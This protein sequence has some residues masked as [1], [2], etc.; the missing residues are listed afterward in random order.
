VNE[1]TRPGV[2]KYLNQGA[3]AAVQARRDDAYRQMYDSCWGFY[4]IVAEGPRSEGGTA[5]AIGGTVFFDD[6][7]YWYIH[8]KC[9]P[10]PPGYDSRSGDGVGAGEREPWRR[11]SQWGPGP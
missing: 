8:F 3:D 11:P 10:P 2:V 5:A 7:N 9:V 4:E 1:A 6:N